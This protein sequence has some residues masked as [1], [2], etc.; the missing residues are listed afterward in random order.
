MKPKDVD[1]ESLLKFNRYS[2]Y[3]IQSD[4]AYV[5]NYKFPETLIQYKHLSD[6]R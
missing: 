3:Q 5:Q 6:R 1:A 2:T 4:E